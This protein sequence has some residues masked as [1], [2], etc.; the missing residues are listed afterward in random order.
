MPANFI[1]SRI[2]IQNWHTPREETYE[3]LGL[4]R[5]DEI[6][7]LATSFNIMATQLKT[8]FSNLENSNIELENRI[9][10]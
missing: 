4:N 2:F 9:I 7:R 10:D 6:G 8:N 3:N 5:E 1:Q